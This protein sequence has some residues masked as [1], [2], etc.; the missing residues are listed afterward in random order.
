[1]IFRSGISADL[2]REAS[3]EQEHLDDGAGREGM[4][5]G[6]SG[7]LDFRR[8]FTNLPAGDSHD[9]LP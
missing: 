9:F 7:R 8:C 6:P 4:H 1:M 3:L 2:G 5:N